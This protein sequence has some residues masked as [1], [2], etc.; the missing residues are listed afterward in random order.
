MCPELRSGARWL[1]PD[2]GHASVP[3]DIRGVNNG[4]SNASP[5]GTRIARNCSDGSL[6][7]RSSNFVDVCRMDTREFPWGSRDQRPRKMAW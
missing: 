4:Y 7:T 2:T 6:G 5:P 1:S 3:D